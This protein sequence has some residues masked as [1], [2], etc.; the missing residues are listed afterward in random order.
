MRLPSDKGDIV[1]VAVRDMLKEHLPATFGVGTGTVYD[2]YDD[3][4]LQADVIITNGDHP[5]RYPQDTPGAYIIDGVSAVGEVKSVLTTGELADCIEKGTAF[6]RLR[7]TTR[8][9]DLIPD[10]QGRNLQIEMGC[11]PPFFVLAIENKVAMETIHERLQAAPAVPVPQG[12]E[13][14]AGN[15]NGPQPP[16]DVVCLLGQGVLLYLR[17]GDVPLQMYTADKQRVT[18]WVG[19]S[20]TEAPLATSL[21]WLHALM[22]RILRGTSVFTSYLFPDSRHIKYMKKK[23][24]SVDASSDGGTSAPS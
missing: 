10:S 19:I 3:E 1:E 7:Q 5:L 24:G 13:F 11:T 12:K 23:T 4:S 22:P 18:G 16:I 17:P 9:G 2:A 21:A 15:G 20:D 6:K 14:D 8:A